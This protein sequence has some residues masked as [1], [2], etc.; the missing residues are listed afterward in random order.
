MGHAGEYG[1]YLAGKGNWTIS[2]GK[3]QSNVYQII[4]QFFFQNLRKDFISF[5][6]Y[7]ILNTYIMDHLLIAKVIALL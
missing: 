6:Q 1:L 4:S 3:S 7:V 5:T 2:I